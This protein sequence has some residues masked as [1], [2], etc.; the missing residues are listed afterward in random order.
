MSPAD[1]TY[2]GSLIAA[3]TGV[4]QAEAERRATDTF[5]QV[6]SVLDRERKAAVSLSLWMFLALLG[7]AF[8]ASVTATIGGRQWD[9]A[10]GHDERRLG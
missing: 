3:R 1:R 7:G 9:H 4:A 6:Q 10:A 2:L 8:C 5:T